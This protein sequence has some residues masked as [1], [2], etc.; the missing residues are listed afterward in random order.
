[1]TDLFDIFMGKT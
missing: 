1:M